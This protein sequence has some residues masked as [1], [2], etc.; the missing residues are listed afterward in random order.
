MIWGLQ[1]GHIR[2]VG[3][4]AAGHSAGGCRWS[5]SGGGGGLRGSEAGGGE[6]EGVG[7]MHGC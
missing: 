6:E 3:A 5:C 7:E 1:Q 2:V 4:S